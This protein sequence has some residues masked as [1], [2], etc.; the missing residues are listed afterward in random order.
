[1]SFIGKDIK[2]ININEKIRAKEVRLIDENGKQLGIFSTSEAVRL[3]RERDLDLVE[4]SPKAE[5][6][7]CKIMDFG[8]YKYQLA[9]K[10][11]EAKKKQTVIQVKEI[12]LGLKIEQHDLAFKIN[13]IRDFLSEG[14]K[15]KVVIM[16]KGREIF[17]VDMG[18]K[19]AQKIIDSIKDVGNLENRQKFD[20]RNIVM[21]FAPL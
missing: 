21:V 10:A 17:H 11:Q 12:K 3:A 5:P 15:V 14:N 19:L 2:D 6:P 13:H 7:V 8:K 9:K 4:I 16:F 1:M 20:G 18:E